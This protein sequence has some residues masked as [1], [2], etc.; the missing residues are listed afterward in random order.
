MRGHSVDAFEDSEKAL[1]EFKPD[2]YDIRFIKKPARIGKIAGELIDNLKVDAK[3]R[4]VGL[5]PKGLWNAEDKEA[6]IR[7]R[8]AEK[9]RHILMEE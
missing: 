6:V 2:T 8:P 9:R 7:M 1:Q 4:Q 5:T 3:I